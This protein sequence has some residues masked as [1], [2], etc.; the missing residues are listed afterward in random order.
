MNENALQIV[1]QPEYESSL[2]ISEHLSFNF[3]RPMPGPLRRFW[4]RLLL[5]WRWTDYVEWK[6]E[7]E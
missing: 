6:P 1:G 4:V 2:V 7:A 3:T 5:G